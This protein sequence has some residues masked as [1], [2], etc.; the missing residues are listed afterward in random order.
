MIAPLLRRVPRRGH[1]APRAFSS[2]VDPG[3]RQENASNQESR[4]PFRFYR[5]G[6]GSRRDRRPHRASPCK[7]IT[8]FRAAQTRSD[9]AAPIFDREYVSASWN[10]ARVRTQGRNWMGMESLVKSNIS[11]Q[12]RSRGIVCGRRSLFL[13]RTALHGGSQARW[14]PNELRQ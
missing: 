14:L 1:R 12:E 9:L 11:S 2:E 8:D 5:N 10:G 4:A 7:L 13:T 3:S 6:K